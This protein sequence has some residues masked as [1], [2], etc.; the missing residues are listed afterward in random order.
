MAAFWCAAQRF[1][2][3][4]VE[5]EMI[6]EPTE[7]Q[8]PWNL[9]EWASPEQLSAWAAAVA[10][11]LDWNNPE[12]DSWLRGRTDFHPQALLS[13]LTLAYALGIYEADEI[14]RACYEQPA[15]Q[16]LCPANSRPAG[17]ELNKF[18]KENRGLVKFCL[19]E[20]F[21]YVFRTRFELGE[22]FIP[23]GIRKHLLESA[24]TRLDVARQ[25]N[26]GAEGF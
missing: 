17:A 12:L 10:A 8:L 24:V 22:S 21:K 3:M 25:L 19:F 23:A 16:R 9:A 15:F 14:E 13:I 1:F 2:V 26:R 20:L 4:L 5:S 18:R 6:K 11:S 7:L